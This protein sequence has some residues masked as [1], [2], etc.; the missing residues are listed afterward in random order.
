MCTKP[1]LF[2]AFIVLTSM[3]ISCSGVSITE[4]E[5]LKAENEQ[6]KKELDEL[7]FGADRL[8]SKAKSNL[9]LKHFEDAKANLDSLIIKHPESTLISEA[10]ELIE[11]AEKEIA[12]SKAAEAKAKADAE[13]AER[14]RLTNATRLMRT[15]YDDVNEITWYYDKTTPK[16]SLSNSI[17]IYMG[18][19]KDG[20]PW[21]RFYT[22][23]SSDDWLFIKKLTIKTDENTHSIE[24][25]YGDVERDHGSGTIWEWYDVSMTN[26]L[27]KICQDI[28]SSKSSKLRYVGDQYHKD[29]VITAQEKQAMQNVL[30]A[31]EALGGKLIF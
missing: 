5:K 13:K 7:K 18:K 19:K 14:D 8:L 10:K 25:K 17:Y 31:Y 12:Q 3:L 22:Q 24:P 16:T 6:L 4:H 1:T 9:E 26:Y 30:N 28:I 21:L 11:V 29:K 2:L 15:S 20:S 23:Y 27:Y